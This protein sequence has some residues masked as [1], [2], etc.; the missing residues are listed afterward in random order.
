MASPRVDV[1]PALLHWA[2]K[3]GRVSLEELEKKFRKLP[4][5]LKKK[6]QPTLKQLEGFAKA[7]HTPIG[8][9]MLPSPPNETMPIAD[10]RTL[11]S[12]KLKRPSADLLETIYLCERRQAWFRDQMRHEVDALDWVGSATT[13]A[14]PRDVA[15]AMAEK[16]DFTL[17]ER[18]RC[19]TW[20]KALTC[21]MDAAEELGVMVMVNG[22]VGNNTHRKLDPEE[23]RGFVLADPIAPVVFVNGADS[24]AAQMFTLTHELA[25]LW[26]GESGLPD[27]STS[28]KAAEERWCNAVAAEFLV[29]AKEIQAEFDS[30]ADLDKEIKRLAKSFKVSTLV[31]LRRLGDTRLISTKLFRDSYGRENARVLA[32]VKRKKSGG[33]DF[34]RTQRRRVSSVFAH[35]LLASAME[36]TTLYREALQLMSMSKVGTLEE[37]ASRMGIR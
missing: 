26:L 12:A 3:R 20:E 8:Y 37:M 15:E 18:K 16:L 2:A 31:I 35:A 25:H 28:P 34:Y 7:T 4:E 14:D 27:L 19:A 11:K 36:G 13:S 24:K 9:L 32:L 17:E 23:F 6:S 10:F 5:W 1:E 22:C 21:L 33:G 30:Q 29:P